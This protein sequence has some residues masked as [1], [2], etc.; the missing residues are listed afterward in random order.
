MNQTIY[1]ALENGKVFEGKSFGVLPKED[2]ICGEIFFNTDVVGFVENI[3]DTVNC[4]KIMCCT[5]PMVGNYGV[6]EKDMESALPQITGLVIKDY[7]SLPSNYRLEESIEEFAKKYNICGIYGVDT[8]EITKIV[9]ENGNLKAYIL[10]DLANLDK[11][12]KCNADFSS[13]EKVCSSSQ[14]LINGNDVAVVSFGKDK[15]LKTFLDDKSVKYD[16]LYNNYD[17]EILKGYKK[18]IFAEGPFEYVDKICSF[19]QKINV[20]ETKFF[21]IGV[22][23]IALAKTFG[24]KVEK[25]K[26][27][28]SGSNQPVKSLSTNKTI[29]AK[30]NYNYVVTDSKDFDITYKNINNDLISGIDFKNGCLG[31]SFNICSSSIPNDC[32]N[33]LEE[34]LNK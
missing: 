17:A 6:N 34:F 15:A 8:R 26:C 2:G 28:H 12:K 13:V 24:C 19:I 16:I 20:K 29:I 14:N 1:L 3:T 32:F 23:F 4:G 9:R 25:M 22:G 21:G 27:G 10:T 11:V 7:C 5:F 33:A 30:E 18:V 31:I